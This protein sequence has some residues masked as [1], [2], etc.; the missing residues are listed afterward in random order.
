M[1]SQLYD[2]QMAKLSDLDC[3]SQVI[4]KRLEDYKRFKQ[5]PVYK[6]RLMG[7]HEEFADTKKS[8]SVCMSYE[9]DESSL[10]H[11]AN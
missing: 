9:E 10:T 2:P 5:D 1:M 3:F 8:M 4:F 11:R 6:Q 7:D